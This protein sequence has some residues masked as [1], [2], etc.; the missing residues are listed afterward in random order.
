[1]ALLTLRNISLSYGHP[2]LLDDITLTLQPKQRVCLMGRNGEGKSTLLK[3]IANE[4]LPDTGERLLHKGAQIA[5]LEQEVP[6]DVTGLS[7]IHISEPTRLLRS[8]MPS[9]A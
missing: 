1:M 7:L 4:T 9:S 6:H 2:T 3:V 5:R 8:R